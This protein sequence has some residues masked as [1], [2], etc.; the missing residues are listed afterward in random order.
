VLGTIVTLLNFMRCAK[1]FHYFNKI[2][3]SFFLEVAIRK[4]LITSN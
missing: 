4:T 1:E 2:W 3:K